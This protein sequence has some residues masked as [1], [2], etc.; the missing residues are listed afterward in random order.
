MVNVFQ[1]QKKAEDLFE[2]EDLGNIKK[3]LVR[4]DGAAKNCKFNVM[5]D[6]FSEI[7]GII[8]SR[9]KRQFIEVENIDELSPKIRESLVFRGE[10]IEMLGQRLV[11]KCECRLR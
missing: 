7:E 2:G 5:M 4:A 6:R 9:N 1:A 3:A 11:E 8:D 10:V